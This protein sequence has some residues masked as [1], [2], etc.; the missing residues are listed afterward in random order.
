MLFR[1][2]IFNIFLVIIS[3]FNPKC[4]HTEKE[5]DTNPNTGTNLLAVQFHGSIRVEPLLVIYNLQEYYT[6]MLIPNEN[7]SKIRR[8]V[9][10]NGAK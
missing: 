5:R 3:V 1:E 7:H 9:H 8:N 4:T 10:E 6:S 2:N